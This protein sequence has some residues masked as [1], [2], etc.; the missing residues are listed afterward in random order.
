MLIVINFNPSRS[1]FF[2]RAYQTFLFCNPISKMFFLGTPLM[3]S[4]MFMI[5]VNVTLVYKNIYV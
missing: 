2:S 1:F 4:P 3:D 5:R